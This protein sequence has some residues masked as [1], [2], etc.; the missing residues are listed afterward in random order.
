MRQ[1]ANFILLLE[2][3]FRQMTKITILRSIRQT[4]ALA[5]ILFMASTAG[6]DAAETKIATVSLQT[7][8]DK[9]IAGKNA[10]ENLKARAENERSILGDKAQK[11]KELE[12]ELES[13]RLMMRPETVSEKERTLRKLKREF[14]LYRG[15]TEGVLKRE[16]SQVMRKIIADIMR[17]IKDYGKENKY[18]AILQKTSGPNPAGPMVLYS[19]S[20]IDVTK[21]VIEIYDKEQKSE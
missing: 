20:A 11:I 16:Q 17:I 7:I 2:E 12:K 9:S 5:F 19:D 18:T 13:Q 6:A 3:L 1:T 4:T 14:E 15:D 8:M 21:A 10:L